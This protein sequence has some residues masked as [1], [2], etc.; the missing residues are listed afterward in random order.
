MKTMTD[1][2]NTREIVLDLLME[3]TKEKTPSHVVHGAML[4]K[5]QY[6]DKRERSFISRLFKGTMERMITLDYV[7]G[8][9]SSVKVSKI[10]PVI[11]NILRMSVYQ[12]LYMEG[13]PDS[14]ACNE[15]AN[16]AGRRGFKNL[17]GFVNG[18]LRN[19]GRKK[20]AIVWPDAAKDPVAALSVAYALPQWLVQSWLSEYDVK[21]VRVMAASFLEDAPITI[22]CMD[23]SCPEKVKAR[24]EAEGVHVK[25]G[26]F[27]PYAWQISDFDYLNS[28][29][30]FNEGLFCVQDESSMMVVEAADLKAGERVLDVCA[31]PG[32]KSLHAA[33]KLYALGDG[34]VE[35]RDVT[36]EKVEKIRENIRRMGLKN[37]NTLVA[38]ALCFRPQDTGCA[39]VV[40]A[41][42]PCS[43]LGVLGRKADIKLNMTPEKT[44]ELADL[45][46]RILSVVWQYVAEGGRLIYSTCTINPRENEENARW[47]ADNFPFELKSMRQFLPGFDGCDGFFIAVFERE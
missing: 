39:N 18:V 16:L 44:C 41:D 13:I 19:I 45:Q 8:Q 1:S 17:K 21:T 38:D 33:A 24:L 4:T 40:L 42:L 47:F 28:L 5:Y 23:E 25:P 7:I 30:S 46:R 15:A 35:A 3:V 29:D 27:L 43:G 32:G 31:A 20:G 10:K 6:L 2:I 22:R 11:R 12:M 14:A 26:H 36:E 37:I 9:F 34:I